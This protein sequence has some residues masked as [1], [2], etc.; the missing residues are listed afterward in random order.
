MQIKLTHHNKT[1][2]PNN[3]VMTINTLKNGN[4]KII[5]ILLLNVNSQNISLMTTRQIISTSII[6]R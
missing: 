3:N 6:T 5:F 1:Q 2:R 4:S